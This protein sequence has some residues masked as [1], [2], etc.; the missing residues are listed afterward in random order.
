M[1]VVVGLF[2]GVLVSQITYASQTGGS[3]IAQEEK[4]L[5]KLV[6]SKLNPRIGR[7]ITPYLNRVQPTDKN[8]HKMVKNWLKLYNSKTK[9]PPIEHKSHISNWDTSLI[10]DMSGLFKNAVKF[11]DDISQWNTSKVTNMNGMFEGAKTFNQPIGNWDTG[12]V[13]DMSNMFRDATSFNKYIGCWDT[14]KVKTM[15]SMF[16][17]A[18]TFNQD[19]RMKWCTKEDGTE[20]R[21]WNIRNVKNIDF[22]FFGAT[23][24]NQPIDNWVPSAFLNKVKSYM[25]LGATKFNQ[26]LLSWGIHLEDMRREERRFAGCN[27]TYRSR[28][29][30]LRDY[31][32]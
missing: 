18:E 15:N 3:T 26:N 17:R 2:V 10:T 5:E 13:T 23:S 14:T 27:L 30:D 1:D 28:A 32:D 25:F 8:I 16:F 7:F 19:I 24:F 4:L 6:R 11:N 21:S 22:M 12:N 20:Y 9:F 31:R 29:E